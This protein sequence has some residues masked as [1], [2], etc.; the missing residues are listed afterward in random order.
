MS[1]TGVGVN[2]L[3]VCEGAVGDDRGE[4]LRIEDG[5]RRVISGDVEEFAAEYPAIL[6]AA[7]G[8]SS[9]GPRV[10]AAAARRVP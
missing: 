1:G 2:Y 9:C 7:A 4:A 5:V 8:G 3:G 10:S 6:P